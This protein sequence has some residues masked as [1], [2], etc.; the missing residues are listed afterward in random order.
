M[1]TVYDEAL[2]SAGGARLADGTIDLTAALRSL[3][4]G[5]PTP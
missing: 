3:L 2:A 1:E 5:M 4:E